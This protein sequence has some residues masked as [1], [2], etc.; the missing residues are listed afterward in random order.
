M[1]LVQVVKL[2][3]LSV[4]YVESKKLEQI[5]KKNDT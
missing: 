1:D 2:K 4:K 3:R 5:D